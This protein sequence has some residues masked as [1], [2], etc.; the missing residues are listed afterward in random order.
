MVK[1]ALM[2]EGYLTLCECTPTMPFLLLPLV[3]SSAILNQHLLCHKYSFFELN[4]SSSTLST[5]SGDLYTPLLFAGL[6]P[7][8]SPAIASPAAAQPSSRG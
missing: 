4:T 8:C 7:H 6:H 5:S 1:S 3:L 2:M